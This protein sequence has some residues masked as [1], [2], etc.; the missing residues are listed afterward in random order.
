MSR[1]SSVFF[2]LFD[3][4]S[5]VDVLRAAAHPAPR[6]TREQPSQFEIAHA[7]RFAGPTQISTSTQNQEEPGNTGA[8]SFRDAA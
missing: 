5:L 7:T 2:S 3:G 6:S 1:K 4:I 8:S